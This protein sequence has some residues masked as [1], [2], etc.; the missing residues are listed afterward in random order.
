M[1]IEQKEKLEAK[2]ISLIDKNIK[3]LEFSRKDLSELEHGAAD[4][5][6]QSQSNQT[7]ATINSINDAIKLEIV[8]LRKAL[9]NIRDPEFGFCMECG[10]DIDYE[11]LDRNPSVINCFDCQ[12]LIE[13]DR[14]RAA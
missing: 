8:S 2:I 13:Q 1:N 11:R 7:Q 9:K 4:P 3:K 10:I 5:L 14:S 6:D 12:T